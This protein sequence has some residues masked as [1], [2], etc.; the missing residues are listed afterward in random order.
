MYASVHQVSHVLSVLIHSGT[1]LHPKE[2]VSDLCTFTPHDG[3]KD[4]VKV[5]EVYL[6]QTCGN[7]AVKE[8]ELWILDIWIL[9]ENVPRM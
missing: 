1:A 5:F 2:E 8:D 7:A 4:A 3:R 9:D 6:L